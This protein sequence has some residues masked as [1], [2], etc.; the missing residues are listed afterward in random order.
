MRS[1][2]PT[3]RI[4]VELPEVIWVSPVIYVSR[5]SAADNIVR[6]KKSTRKTPLQVGYEGLERA[7]E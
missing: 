5:V 2:S 1:L 6:E 4:P 7:C 3:I